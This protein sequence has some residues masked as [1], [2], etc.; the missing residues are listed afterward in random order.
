MENYLKKLKEIDNDKAKDVI[1]LIEAINDDTKEGA[2]REALEDA[3]E[4]IE[5][6]RTVNDTREIL[7][8]ALKARFND[9]FGPWIVDHSEVAPLF[10]IYERDGKSTEQSDYS[11]DDSHK[12]TLENPVNVV[13]RTVYDVVTEAKKN[14]DSQFDLFEKGNRETITGDYIKLIESTVSEDGTIPIKII[15]PGWGSSGYYPTEVLERDAG[16]YTEGTKMYWNHPT[17]TED[18]ERPERSLNDLA[19]VLVSEGVYDSDGIEG[20]GVYAKA[21][22]FSDYQNSINDMS[23]DIGLSHIAGGM[24]TVGEREGKTGRIIESL[25]VAD[26]IDFV[27]TPGAGG[28][29]IQLFE[30]ARNSKS[31]P[32]SIKMEENKELTQLKESNQK[33]KDEIDRLKEKEVLSDAKEFVK[34]KLKESELPDITKARLLD[35]LSRNPAT[36]DKGALDLLKFGES[37]KKGIEDETSYL[38]KLSDSGKITGMGSST[39]VEEEKETKVKE[40]LKKSFEALGFEGKALEIAV[41]GR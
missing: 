25:N 23:E 8:T 38:A 39:E 17:A 9:E 15:Q 27:T 24:A 16:I 4:L 7:R 22:V 12:V 40:S 10:V 11:I 33:Y 29:I 13:P 6:H 5:A 28:Q 3:I 41:N 14:K 21:K 19:A 18:I 35:S 20:P 37:V 32:K 1:K 34:S 36:D 30:S 31:L 2:R 26:S